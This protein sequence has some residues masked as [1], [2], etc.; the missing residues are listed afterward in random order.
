MGGGVF[1]VIY[2]WPVGLAYDSVEMT[3]TSAGRD[4]KGA[5][6]T[7]VE[8]AGRD[9]LA[10]RGLGADEVRHLLTRAGRYAPV[11][12]RT[13]T[14]TDELAG[15]TVA[16]MMFEPSTRTRVSFEM[17]ATR[18]GARVVDLSS[19]ASSVVKG[20][21]LA[22]TARTIEAM[23]VSAMV[24]RTKAV[25]GAGAVA[26]AVGC[27][28]VNAGDGRHEHPTQGLLD[29]L[30][31]ARS[32][33]R[34]D[35][36]DLSGLR[37]GIV[38]D[39]VNSRVARSA[40]AGFSVL[41]AEVVCVGPPALVPELTGSLG[42]GVERDLDKVLPE[43]D[44]VMMLRVQF[45]RHSGGGSPLGSVRQY[46]SG[47]AM[48]V[49]RAGAMK[50]GAIVMHPGPLNQGVEID[51]AVADGPRSVILKQVANGVAVRMAVLGLV[52]EG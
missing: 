43:L 33:D 32:F 7:P 21:S 26:R 24:V 41:G 2:A 14:N 22:D 37:V 13:K 48:T 3:S 46:R 25:G 23:G 27:P 47:Y 4:V 10:L 20:E 39:V 18:L 6:P 16:L 51:A 40:I 31:A 29:V 49:E 42:C 28:V 50:Q 15:R 1:F 11:A 12:N 52:C 35:G 38:G 34:A 19:G 9:L 36:F 8:W 45:E 5:A 17:A 30:T 44:V